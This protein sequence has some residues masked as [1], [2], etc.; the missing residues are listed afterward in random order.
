MQRKEVQVALDRDGFAP[1]PEA[2]R[3]H[4]RERSRCQSFVGDLTSIVSAAHE[5]PAEVEPPGRVWASLRAQLEEEGILSRSVRGGLQKRTR[6]PMLR[7]NRERPEEAPLREEAL[8]QSEAKFLTLAETIASAIFISRGKR[9]QYV[10]HAA[11]IITGYAREELSSMN[12]WDLVHPN[13]RELVLNRGGARQGD[14]SQYEGKILRKNGDERWLDIST[15]MVE[16][17]GML[18]TL[19]SAFVLTHRNH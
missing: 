13:C 17:E 15:A 16:F 18:A 8:R 5:L 1:V 10:N 19:L 4:L 7:K 14:A 12:F 11:E 6:L 2:A 9:L 3:T